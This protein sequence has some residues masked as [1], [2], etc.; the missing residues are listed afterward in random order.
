MCNLE[1]F[2]W[3][4]CCHNLKIFLFSSES[5]KLKIVDKL[6]NFFAKCFNIF[7][8]PIFPFFLSE[9]MENL[10][11]SSQL[12][13]FVGTKM[14]MI[15]WLFF[16]HYQWSVTQH[17]DKAFGIY[18]FFLVHGT[19]KCWKFYFCLSFPSIFLTWRV[20]FSFLAFGKNPK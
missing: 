18:C 20:F 11:F 10:K 13:D 8:F 6:L 14:I 16:S 12:S 9:V 7:P 19:R 4:K 17:N 5:D 15:S 1:I 2:S 3:S